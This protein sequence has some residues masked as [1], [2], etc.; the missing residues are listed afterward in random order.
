VTRESW[1]D[2]VV[3]SIDVA[4]ASCR[5]LPRPDSDEPP[6]LGT[7][8]AAGLRAEVLAWDDPA[9]DF[10]AARLTLLRSTWNYAE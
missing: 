8:R 7:L 4:L 5:G 9:A 1:Q 2:A 3:P 10:T 6:L